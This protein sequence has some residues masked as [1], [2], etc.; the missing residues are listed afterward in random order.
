MG[1]NKV[2]SL[3]IFA[4][5]AISLQI[6]DCG[7]RI[8]LKSAITNPKWKSPDTSA[9]AHVTKPFVDKAYGYMALIIEWSC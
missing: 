8:S 4:D 7:F 9:G 3:A 5:A 2:V 6:G 1:F